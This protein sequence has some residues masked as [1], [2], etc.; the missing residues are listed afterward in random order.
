MK[1]VLVTGA[2][3]FIGRHVL[4]LLQNRGQ[5]EIHAASLDALD[6]AYPKV[7]WYQVDLLNSCQ[8]EQLIKNVRPELLMHFAWYAV[9]GQYWTSDQNLFWE[10]SSIELIK[11]FYENGGKRLVGVGTCAE[12]SWD[13]SVLAEDKTPLKPAT[14]YGQSKSR[15]GSF[16]TECSRKLGV[17]SAWG[18]I[19]FLYGP[20]ENAHR[21]VP[22][23]I[24]SLLQNQPALCTHGEQ[25]RD[26][27]YVQD[28]AAAFVALLESSVEG[29][30]NIA[31]GQ[32]V[33]LKEIIMKIADKLGRRQLVRLGALAGQVN[34]PEVLEA[35]VKKLSEKVGWHP[36]F[37]LDA[38]LELTI[39]WWKKALH[40]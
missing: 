34:D 21:L 3:G 15:V 31:S 8:A 9:P 25:I 26:F 38:G 1:K 18:R 4:K 19:F 32:P 10:K 36:D 13:S 16:L 28:V 37:S 40:V 23:V 20:Y 35:D 33:A 7:H 14:I 17:S 11:G 39:N 30:V 6:I 29:P 24:C 27:L 12:Y 5:Y 2:T 22:S